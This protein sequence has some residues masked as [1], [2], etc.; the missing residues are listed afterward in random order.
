MQAFERAHNGGLTAPSAWDLIASPTTLSW[1]ELGHGPER[2][3]RSRCPAPIRCVNGDLTTP[4][5]WDFIASPTTLSWKDLG[6]R[7]E[8]WGAERD[9][10]A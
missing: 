2:W 5:A 9:G 10:C 6:H 1:K 7:Q 8:R 4:P 3:G